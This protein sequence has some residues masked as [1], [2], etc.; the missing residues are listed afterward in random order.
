MRSMSCMAKRTWCSISPFVY[1]HKYARASLVVFFYL[2][3]SLL[4]SCTLAVPIVAG[5]TFANIT[6]KLETLGLW[7]IMSLGE[8]IHHYCHLVCAQS[9]NKNL[10]QTWASAYNHRVF[11]NSSIC[12]FKY[13]CLLTVHSQDPV[14]NWR[15]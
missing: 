6:P 1:L 10:L 11:L 13:T 2:F 14:R 5:D 4:N 8:V 3:D 9:V 12:L 15:K 7:F